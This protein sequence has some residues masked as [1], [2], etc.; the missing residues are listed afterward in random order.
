MAE[1]AVGAT[2]FTLALAYDDT[3]TVVRVIQ[4]QKYLAEGR[5]RRKK[6]DARNIEL[7][8][9]LATARAFQQLADREQAHADEILDPPKPKPKPV[10]VDPRIQKILDD[11]RLCPGG[12]T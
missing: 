10:P 12:Q 11:I 4:D 2:E 5:A 6:G 7:G 3:D 1:Q 9:S 8:T